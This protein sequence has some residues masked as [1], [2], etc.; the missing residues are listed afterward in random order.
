MKNTQQEIELELAWLVASL[1]NNL[2]QCK[3][4]K[5]VQAYLENSDPHI[6]DARVREKGGV[7]TYTI[8]RFAKNSQE[9]GY[10][11][12]ET[13]EIS[14]EKFLKLSGESNKKI[15]KTRYFY[16]LSQGLTA[17]IDIY[18]ENLTGLSVVEVEFPNIE[19]YKQFVP[20][21]WFGKEVS[22]SYGIYPPFIAN[23][24]IEEVNAINQKYLQ[25]PHNFD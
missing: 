25:K 21:N 11:T 4:I 16:P 1:P 5:I 7:Y 6:K 18:E 8:K 3:N 14:R 19:A 23:L 17:E 13:R 20:P 24:S 10:C 22:D 9:T 15:T 12:E 2:G